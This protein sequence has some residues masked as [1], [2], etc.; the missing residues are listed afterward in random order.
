MLF[1]EST[2]ARVGDK[3]YWPLSYI[4]NFH[5][6]VLLVDIVFFSCIYLGMPLFDECFVY[7]FCLRCCSD[8]RCNR[9]WVPTQRASQKITGSFFSA[10]YVS[11]SDEQEAKRFRLYEQTE[12]IKW[13]SSF[14]LSRQMVLKT[15]TLKPYRS[16]CYSHKQLWSRHHW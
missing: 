1:N 10:A 12:G 3:K 7:T 8:S 14:T 11:L 5:S 9:R 13:S 6:T 16:T 2:R 4:G 15:V